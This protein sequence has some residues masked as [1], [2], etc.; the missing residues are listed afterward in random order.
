MDKKRK[1]IICLVIIIAALLIVT[2]ILLL[3]NNKKKS[4]SSNNNISEKEKI[5]DGTGGEYYC[6]KDTISGNLKYKNI[7][8]KSDENYTFVVSSENKIISQGYM[9]ILYFNNSTDLQD[10]YN[11]VKDSQYKYIKGEKELT[12]IHTDLSIPGGYEIFSQDYL[13]FLSNNGYKCNKVK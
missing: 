1:L 12:L 11:Y 5:I 9:N 7:K 3:H 13:V 10:Y 2:G 6:K 4:H 8:V